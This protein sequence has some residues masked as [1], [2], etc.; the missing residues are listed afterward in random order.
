[1]DD[2]EELLGAIEGGKTD[3]M[4]RD[5]VTRKKGD[6]AITISDK[7]D[8]TIYLNGHTLDG[9]GLG[10]VITVKDGGELT[11][12]NSTSDDTGTPGKIT[13]GS[14]ANGN[15]GGIY[16]EAGGTVTIKGNVEITGNT[17]TGDK[18]TAS[19]LGGGVYNEGT[20]KDGG[21]RDDLRE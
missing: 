8:L 2:W 20:F 10:S 1:M 11:I 14:A 5:N 18:T 16:I 3:I 21:R 9:A 12:Q 4:L 19:G 17:A 13:G 15:G 7:K 6:A